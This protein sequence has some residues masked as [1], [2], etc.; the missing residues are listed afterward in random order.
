MLPKRIVRMRIMAETTLDKAFPRVPCDRH[1]LRALL[2][3]ARLEL[4]V[5][6]APL[7][8]RHGV[9]TG[10]PSRDVTAAARKALGPRRQFQ[11]NRRSHPCGCVVSGE[12]SGAP[13]SLVR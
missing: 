1:S 4:E 10:S 9:G 12:A 3:W 8:V 2:L 11:F 6:R 5:C 7:D 13:Q